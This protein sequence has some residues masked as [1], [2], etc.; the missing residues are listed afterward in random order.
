[1]RKVRAYT[2]LGLAVFLSIVLPAGRTVW[3]SVDGAAAGPEGSGVVV[4]GSTE[5][6]DDEEVADMIGNYVAVDGNQISAERLN[7]S[8]IDYD[9]L[10]S[11]IHYYNT[12]IQE[13][14]GSTERSREDYTYIRDTLRAERDSA[15]KKK[16][17]AKDDGE[18]EDYA[19]YSGYQAVYSSAVESYNKMINRLDSYSSNQSRLS[20]EKQL[21]NSAQSLM[22]SYWSASLQADYRN[23]MEE[24]YRKMYEDTVTKQSAGL[25]TDQDVL[26]SY[27]N[28]LS[29][30]ASA[31]SANDGATDSYRNLCLLLGVDEQGSMSIGEIPE[32]DESRLNAYDLEAD[33]KKAIDNNTDLISERSSSTDSTASKTKKDRTM[34]DYENQIQVKMSDRYENVQ[35][36]KTAYEAAE[37]GYHSAGISWNNAQ[38]KYSMGML[39]RAE[40]L[41]E[42]L[43]YIQKEADYK[44]AQLSLLQ[45]ME[46]YDWAV[47]GIMDL[48]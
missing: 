47:K 12:S 6:S 35:S 32:I 31:E 14:T 7:D 45:A 10:G 21:T 8:V 20:Q 18:T 27:N 39:S 17:D 9:E 37:T 38:S 23:K 24:L 16:K 13:L 33:T 25:A 11:L 43:T 22:V 5:E 1:M 28:W 19:E 26:T 34:A 41:E 48:D 44:S 42:E 46:T 2:S 4:A 15:I 40:Y 30:S 3:A 36:A 29:M